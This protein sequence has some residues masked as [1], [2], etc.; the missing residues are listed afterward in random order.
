VNLENRVAVITGATGGLGSVVTRDLAA[1]G[2]KLALLDIDP[3]RL[4]ALTGDLSL[5]ESRLLTQAVD[6]LQAAETQLAAQSI[7]EYFGKV[8][9][10]L[11]LVGGWTGGKTLTEVPSE[12]LAFMLKQHIWT[13]L[14]VVQ[15][16]VPHLVKNGWGRIVM[17]TSPFASRPNAKGGPYAIGKA[18]QEALM[19]TLSQELKG[20]GVT[21]NLLQAKTIDAKRE[22][23]SNPKP[24]NASW[25]TPEELSASI[26]HLLSDEAGTI[27]GAKI[28]LYGS[29]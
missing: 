18:G 27:N 22:K 3:K 19:L 7:L 10:L 11:H 13:S 12:D 15:A 21:A 5:P 17:I 25:T 8:D 4:A 29:Y 20:T 9:I 1:R 26:L 2:A 24:E 14:Y 23:V 6:L 16:F 28:P